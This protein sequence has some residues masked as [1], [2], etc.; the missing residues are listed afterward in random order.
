MLTESGVLRMRLPRWRKEKIRR[1]AKLA[2]E[3]MTEYA[4]IA[5]DRRINA[6]RMAASDN[7]IA[8]A[9]NKY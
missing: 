8:A 7:A 4:L 1:A 3:S 2:G 5:I 6:D 9:L